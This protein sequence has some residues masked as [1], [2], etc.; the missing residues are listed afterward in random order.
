MKNINKYLSGIF[1]GGPILN[2]ILERQL[3]F[4]LFVFALVIIYI[5]L[6]YAV[7]QTFVERRRLERELK[8]LHAEYRSCTA[9][10]MFLSKREEVSKHLAR[11]GS[12]VKAPAVPPKRIKME[13]YAYE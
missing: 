12:K 2:T 8:N 10:L 3:R 11:L 7:G 4:I 5:S 6:H 9:E 1:G 13:E